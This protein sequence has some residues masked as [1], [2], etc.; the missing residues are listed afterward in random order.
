MPMTRRLRQ[1]LCQLLIATLLFSQW[2]VASHAC[3]ALSTPAPSST[4]AH[5]SMSDCEHMAG[6][7]D[8]APKNLCA[9]HC[10]QGQQTVDR[11][12]APNLAA[13]LLASVYP[14]PLVTERHQR[15]LPMAASPGTFV[16]ASP[17][18]EILHCC[19]RI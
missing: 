16:A 18:H 13:A 1:L 3:A 7:H 19:F 4:A 2:A 8:P 17:P 11:A 6:M 15:D 5:V 10:Q 12:D 14:L 9:E